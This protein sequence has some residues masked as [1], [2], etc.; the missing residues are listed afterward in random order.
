[1]TDPER[2][3]DTEDNYKGDRRAISAGT[4]VAI[5]TGVGAAMFAATDEPVWI[6]LGA[7]IG[8]AFGGLRSR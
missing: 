8:A 4:G 5:G 6:A 2:E 3:N 1:M 7:G